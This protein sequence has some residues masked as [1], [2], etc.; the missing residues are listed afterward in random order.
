MVW[1]FGLT[2]G[3]LALWS[4]ALAFTAVLAIGLAKEFWD[5]RYGSGFCW[6]DMAGNLLGC[7]AGL[8]FGLA[9]SRI[10]TVG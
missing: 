3:A 10:L 8:C 4:A 7:T 9:V 1:S 2:L 5:A 6:F